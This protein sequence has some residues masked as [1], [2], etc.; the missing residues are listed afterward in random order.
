MPNHAILRDYC[1]QY[2]IHVSLHLPVD[3]DTMPFACYDFT[4]EYKIIDV[5]ETCN[6]IMDTTRSIDLAAN[7]QPLCNTARETDARKLFYQMM[8]AVGGP[9]E[10]GSRDH[11]HSFDEIW[12]HDSGCLHEL[13]N[14]QLTDDLLMSSQCNVWVD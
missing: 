6:G 12:A 10:K 14:A 8:M 11:L 13:Y 3:L 5:I 1:D 4:E 7:D 2:F 9:K